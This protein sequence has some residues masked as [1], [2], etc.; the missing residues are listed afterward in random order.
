MFNTP[1]RSEWHLVGDGVSLLLL[2]LLVFVSLRLILLVRDSVS[3]CRTSTEQAAVKVLWVGVLGCDCLPLKQVAASPLPPRADPECAALVRSVLL[4]GA[5][6][7][8]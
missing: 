8:A 4:D 6:G 7:R 1:P 2:L 3:Q 5:E